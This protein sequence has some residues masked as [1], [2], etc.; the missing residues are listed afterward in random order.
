MEMRVFHLKKARKG[1]PSDR[2]SVSENL[3]RT[4]TEGRAG[5]EA[6]PSSIISP[7]V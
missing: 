7:I 2:A 3:C 6:N 1:I 4:T 5:E